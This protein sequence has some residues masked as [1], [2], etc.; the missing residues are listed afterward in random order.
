MMYSHD[1]QDA[2]ELMSRSDYHKDWGKEE[3]T[4]CI[5]DPLGIRQYKIIRDDDMIPL[6]LATW[7]FP[8]DKQVDNYVESGNFPIKGYKG[9]GKDVWIVDFIAEK[10]Y[11]R[12]G[13]LVLKKMFMRSGYRKAFWYR[14]ESEKLGWHL[15]RGV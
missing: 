3:I 10:G 7:G 15:V 5:E 8:S 2:L 9:D 1:Y 6:V 12:M 11:T 13:F 14:T 4:R